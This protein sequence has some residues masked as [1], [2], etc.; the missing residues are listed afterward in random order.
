VIELFLLV[1]YY[2]AKVKQAENVVVAKFAYMQNIDLSAV[3]L[4]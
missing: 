4:Q 2:R 3:D 1:I